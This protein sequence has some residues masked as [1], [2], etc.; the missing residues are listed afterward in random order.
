[1]A[2]GQRGQQQTGPKEV[3]VAEAR[4]SGGGSGGGQLRA[5][6]P[7]IVRLMTPCLGDCGLFG[8]FTCALCCLSALLC[9]LREFLLLLEKTQSNVLLRKNP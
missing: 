9:L 6:D 2:A 3:V 5:S 8:S 4:S 1:M 7:P